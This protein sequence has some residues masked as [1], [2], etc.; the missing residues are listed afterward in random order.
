MEKMPKFVERQ[1]SDVA[2]PIFN[3]AETARNLVRDI[4]GHV[5]RGRDDLIDRVHDAI[6]RVYPDPRWTRR[7]IRALWHREAARIDW[8]EVRELQFVAEVER[9]ER[10]RRETSRA[11]HN[12]F[13]AGIAA[14]LARLE[15]NDAEFYREHRAALRQMAGGSSDPAGRD[16]ARQGDCRPA[17]GGAPF[18]AG[19]Q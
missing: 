18:G 17:V 4:A 2:A 10:L 19:G 11:A 14:T 6:R 8:R 5:W 9:A 12:E 15:A 16:A 13:V 3:S 7:R 1:M